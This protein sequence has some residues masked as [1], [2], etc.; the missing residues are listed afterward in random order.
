V[1]VPI[2]AVGVNLKYLYPITAATAVILF[3]VD[4]DVD[5]PDAL[6]A[7]TVNVYDEPAISPIT[8][9]GLLVP[10]PVNPPGLLVAV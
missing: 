4:E 9:I 3:D 7:V 5:V 6:V 10:V 8:L 2:R 1:S